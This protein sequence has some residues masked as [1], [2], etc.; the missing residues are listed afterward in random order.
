MI[1]AQRQRSALTG[2]RAIRANV[3]RAFP[4]MTLTDVGSMFLWEIGMRLGYDL[5]GGDDDDS[6]ERRDMMKTRAAKVAKVADNRKG[7]V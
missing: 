6:G 1:Q 3:A 5:I 2:G 4:H 7:T